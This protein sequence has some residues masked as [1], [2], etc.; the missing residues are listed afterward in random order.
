V[1]N[2][3]PADVYLAGAGDTVGY[4]GRTSRICAAALFDAGTA[5]R[6]IVDPSAAFAAI[7]DG[8][9][10]TNAG[11]IASSGVGGDVHRM[12]DGAVAP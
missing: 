9:K 6:L 4:D 7:T 2:V 1:I 8:G 12:H 3:E 5:N 11:V 10:L